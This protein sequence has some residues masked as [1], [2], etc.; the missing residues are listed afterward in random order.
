MIDTL[1]WF[2]DPWMEHGIP[3]EFERVGV[4]VGQSCIECTQQFREQDRG[5]V[6]LCST[7]VWGGFM[8]AVGGSDVRVCGYH[9]R[10]WLALVVGNQ[11]SNTVTDR[12]P[13]RRDEIQEMLGHKGD[14]VV[15]DVGGW[16]QEIA[17]PRGKSAEGETEDGG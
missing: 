7:R 8:L 11:V 4:P 15:H 5:V 14:E 6:T 2:G 17:I 9:L 13:G 16:R 3:A 12:L 1:M 10:C